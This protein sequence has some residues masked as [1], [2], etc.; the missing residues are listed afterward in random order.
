[1]FAWPNPAGPC[2]I[3]IYEANEIY[4]LELNISHPLS[5]VVNFE[6]RPKPLSVTWIDTAPSH[7]RPFNTS[8]NAAT[9][10][11]TFSVRNVRLAHTGIYQLRVGMANGSC[12]SVRNFTLIVRSAPIVRLVQSSVIVPEGRSVVAECVV[13]GS[14]AANISWTWTECPLYLV[15]MDRPWS[16]IDCPTIAAQLRHNQT[17]KVVNATQQRS[18]VDLW[19]G[20]PGRLTCNAINTYS[21]VTQ[22]K[23]VTV[24]VVTDDEKFDDQKILVARQEPLRLRCQVERYNYTDLQ[25]L[26]NGRRSKGGKLRSTVSFQR[27]RYMLLL[28]LNVPQVSDADAGRYECMAIDFDGRQTRQRMLTVHVLKRVRPYFVDGD[29]SPSNVELLPNQQ[30][31]LGCAVGGMPVPV[32]QWL[33]NDQPLKRG[34]NVRIA[35]PEDGVGDGTARNH[36]LTV[37]RVSGAFDGQ[38]RC[39]ANSSAG[40]IERVFDVKVI[41][42]GKFRRS[43]WRGCWASEKCIV[44]LLLFTP[45]LWAK[46]TIGGLCGLVVLIVAV[47]STIQISVIR[48]GTREM[49]T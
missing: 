1:M 4:R 11:T 35:G 22:R 8:C 46:W 30:L 49:L 15:H 34:P 9:S 20:G 26:H 5:W 40:Q 37:W 39:E 43:G 2:H 45:V 48:V 25:W 41:G 19:P 42:L 12:H 17:V 14:P 28:Q 44:F 18:I 33:L 21:N 23:S 29:T 36:T 27:L 24:Y 6:G 13:D 38:L 31:D 7:H 10:L 16:V 32:V 47:C 3:V